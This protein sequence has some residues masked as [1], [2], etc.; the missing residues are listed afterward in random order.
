MPRAKVE[1]IIVSVHVFWGRSRAAHLGSTNLS[2]IN[3]GFNQAHKPKK[4]WKTSSGCIPNHLNPV[5]IPVMTETAIIP[6]RS[7][8]PSELLL[9]PLRPWLNPQ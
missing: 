5:T 8:T 6:E 7:A 3:A 2:V 1:T 4:K 9:Q